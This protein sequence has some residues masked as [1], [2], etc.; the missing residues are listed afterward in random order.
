MKNN[1]LG[2]AFL[3]RSFYL[4]AILAIGEFCASKFLAITTA[5]PAFSLIDSFLLQNVPEQYLNAGRFVGVFFFY[6]LIDFGLTAMLK[7]YFAEKSEIRVNAKGNKHR[8]LFLTIIF[9]LI[10]FRFAATITSSIWAAPEVA[11][12]AT[13]Q[14]NYEYYVN[15]LTTADSLKAAREGKAFSFAQNLSETEQKRITQKADEASQ[16]VKDA[17]ASGD[18]W[19]RASYAKEGFSWLNNRNNKD[20][21]DKAYVKRIKKAQLDAAKLIS[22]EKGKTAAAAHQYEQVKNDSSHAKIISA[23]AT[24]ST[25]AREKHDATIA[26]RKSYVYLAD[27][28]AGAML[29]FCTWLRMLRIRAGGDIIEEKK[30]SLLMI[31]SKVLEKWQ[32]DAITTIETF[33]GVDIDGDGQIGNTEQSSTANSH[34]YELPTPEVSGMGFTAIKNRQ[35]PPTQ[36]DASQHNTATQPT[37]T[38]V[39]KQQKQSDTTPI[40]TATQPVP[41]AT[42]PNTTNPTH[43]IETRV[44]SAPS[45]DVSAWKRYAK[46]Y[47]KRSQKESSEVAVRQRNYATYQEYCELL[48]AAGIQVNETTDSN[49]KPTLDYQPIPRE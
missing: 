14:F 5:F 34:T 31:L 16:L 35:N 24:L 26:S 19:Q 37:D 43:R 28:F 29:I 23:I 1:E 36:R 30:K 33:F 12:K 48:A 4:D 41:Q 2:A 6:L 40:D 7:W 45:Q 22:A 42:Q 46:T 8:Q 25:A 11:N 20:A 13:G 44:V 47:Y 10:V 27:F 15:Q 39:S 38:P 18:Y 17:I 21:K 3:K 32:S 49:G 9:F